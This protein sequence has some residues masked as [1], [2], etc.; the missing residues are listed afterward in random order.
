[1]TKIHEIASE[2]ELL[3]QN[4]RS[5]YHFLFREKMFSHM[6][7]KYVTIF[8]RKVLKMD[9]SAFSKTPGIYSVRDD[10]WPIERSRCLMLE[11]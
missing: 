4:S 2:I 7:L 1:M 5:L 6:Q 9:R 10:S 3:N 11:F 8:I